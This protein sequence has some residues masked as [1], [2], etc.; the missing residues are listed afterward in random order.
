MMVD[1]SKRKR[2]DLIILVV[3][4]MLASLYARFTAHLYIG[5]D[6]FGAFAF[7]V[8]GILY[9][10]TRSQKP[11]KQIA[12]ATLIFGFLCG[13]LFEFIEQFNRS[14]V[15]ARSVIPKLFGVVSFD[16][17]IWHVLMAMYVFTFYEHFIDT[18][19]A[20]PAISSRARKITIALVVS[21]LI[22]IGVYLY[23][24]GWL[25]LRYA[26]TDLATVAVLPLFLLAYHKPRYVRDFTLI[27]PFFLFFFFLVEWTGV[28][29]QWWA[30]GGS[31]YLGWVT[32]RSLHFP[33]EELLYWMLL[34]PATLIAYYK[35]F[36][37]RADT[38][39]AQSSH[40]AARAKP[41]G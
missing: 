33:I 18:T 10:W 5:R 11:A 3:L 35:L 27:S 2:Y 38:Y 31:H 14:Y 39:K 8:P 12:Y 9:L 4:A 37:D 1:H 29:K 40:A 41:T 22:T 17:V 32:V 25:R 34:Y 13:F 30:Y 21:I 36:I 28:P 19:S 16:F 23:D 6:L 26:Y 20:A 24:P 7:C 15:I